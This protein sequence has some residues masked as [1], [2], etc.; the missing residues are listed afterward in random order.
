MRLRIGIGMARMSTLCHKSPLYAS[1]IIYGNALAT[2]G[3]TA[4]GRIH[5]IAVSPPDLQKGFVGAN[6]VVA[7]RGKRG[8]PQKT[9]LR[10]LRVAAQQIDGVGKKFDD[11]FE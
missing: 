5:G 9:L 1:Y 2:R 3:S 11:A 4:A 10:V 7:L 8:R 6:L